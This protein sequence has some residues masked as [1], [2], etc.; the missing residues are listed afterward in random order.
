MSEDRFKSFAVKLEQA[1]KNLPLERLMMNYGF[2]PD[3]PKRKFKHCPFCKKDGAEIS[4]RS[5]R[6]FFKCY[7]T[8][9]PSGKARE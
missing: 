9:C 3:L 4:G 8:S 1:R 7:H 2:A 5:G 6:D